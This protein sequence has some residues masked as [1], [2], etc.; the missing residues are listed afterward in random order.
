MIIKIRLITSIY[1]IVQCLTCAPSLAKNEVYSEKSATTRS[2][3]DPSPFDGAPTTAPAGFEDAGVRKISYWRDLGDGVSLWV[4][5]AYDEKKLLFISLIIRYANKDS[6]NLAP[7]NFQVQTLPNNKVY[8]PSKTHRNTLALA[9]NG[10]YQEQVNLYFPI[11]AETPTG[12]KFLLPMSAINID[13]RYF[14]AIKPFRFSKSEKSVRRDINSYSQ[15]YFLSNYGISAED[16]IKFCDLQI[17]HTAA[18]EIVNST[19]S[20]KEPMSLFLTA[21]SMFQHGKKD[22]AVFWFYASQLRVRYQLVFEKGDRGQL[23]TIMLMTMGPTINNYA[24]QDISNLNRIL[25]KVVEW[26]KKTPNPFREK[27][28]TSE[29]DKQIEQIYTG[30]SDFKIKLSNEKTALE[31]KAKKAAPAIEHAFAEGIKRNTAICRKG[32]FDST[33]FANTSANEESLIKGFVEDFVISSPE[34]IAESKLINRVLIESK[35]VSIDSNFPYQYIT[36]LDGGSK[37]LFAVVDVA[38]QVNSA[39]FTLACITS[40]PK[41]QRNSSTDPCKQ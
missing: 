7:E 9:N 35:S 30:M 12:F 8:T 26:D 36:S 39:K 2:Y 18:E 28:R 11:Q 41:E 21:I 17:V 32:I 25:D 29:M 3:F 38:R 1:C 24:F 37:K 5:P 15:S 23:L 19:T 4:T 27:P 20:L 40:I 31:E 22:E 14:K 13:S 6:L 10:Y 16:R 33:Y 34:A